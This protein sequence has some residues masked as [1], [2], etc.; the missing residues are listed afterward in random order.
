ME[1]PPVATVRL[2]AI[3]A[4]RA[5]VAVVFRRG[6]TRQVELVRWD[7]ASDTIERGQWLKGRIY[8]RRSDL[9]PDGSLL[10]AFVAKY[11]SGIRTWTAVSRPPYLTALAFWPKGDAWGGGGLFRTNTHLLLNHGP[12]AMTPDPE[13]RPVGLRVERL[14]PFAGHG[15]D[16]PIHH[17]RLTR[18][19]W[20]YVDEPSRRD[21]HGARRPV[22]ITFEPALRY[23]R[24]SPSGD[25][26]LERAL[27]G[28]HERQGRWYVERYR[29]LEGGRTVRDFG[30]IDWADWSADGD[31]L[32]AAD[33]RLSRLPADHLLAGDP[34]EVADLRADRFRSVVA[35]GAATRW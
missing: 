24:R 34:R 27:D 33:G 8:E 10:V 16:D 29:L 30:R 5:S 9:S 3:V 21:E 17:V 12:E 31:L 32:I 14:E 13:H 19:G 4:R 35:P 25:L 23:R 11:E 20:A 7:L 6:P 2:S 15:E 26:V 28:I 22:W 18:D 1:R